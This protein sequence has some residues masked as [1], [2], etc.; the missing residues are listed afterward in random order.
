MKSKIFTII[1]TVAALSCLLST[2]VV[3]DSNPKISMSDT[4]L[5]KGETTT[6]PVVLEEAPN[7]VSGYTITTTTGENVE[8]TSVTVGDEFTAITESVSDAGTIEAT[9]TDFSQSVGSGAEDIVLFELEV[10]GSTPGT[11]PVTISVDTFENAGDPPELI[12]PTVDSSQII[13]RE[14]S[15]EENNEVSDN[16]GGDR[17]DSGDGGTIDT[18]ETEETE[19]APTVEPVVERIENAEP[20]VETEVDIKSDEADDTDGVT[21]DTSETSDS[22]SEISFEEST[23]GTVSVS[24]YDDPDVL[25]TTADSI[26]QDLAD[27][28]TEE[29]TAGETDSD[30]ATGSHETDEE[31]TESE[32]DNSGTTDSESTGSV[33]VVTV[34]DISVSSDDEASD[35]A[36]PSTVTMRVAAD[37][38]DNP[39]NAVIMHETDDGWKELETSVEATVD[40]ELVLMGTTE[41]FSLFAVAEIEESTDPTTTESDT[42]NETTPESESSTDDGIPGFGLLVAL[43]ALVSL[44]VLVARR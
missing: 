32:I 25:E 37:S 43:V 1:V 4:T 21:V 19:P 38:V 40:D 30:E 13:V 39:D 8:V 33:S 12:E 42:G 35:D 15:I 31:V 26:A 11:S 36:T 41:S 14:T 3:A 7:G 20:S 27:T 17:G 44:S 28:D 29:E 6:I 5:T 16:N 23:S 10:T 22:V 34:A 2:V 18:E 24:E 9:G